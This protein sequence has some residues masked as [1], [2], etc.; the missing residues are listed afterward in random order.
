MLPAT[1]LYL[2]GA[3]PGHAGCAGLTA[4]RALIDAGVTVAA[5]AD[6]V[7]DP[8]NPTGR[9]DPLE[10]ASL[11]I[12]AGHLDPEEA[13]NAVSGAARSLD[14]S[15]RRPARE[16]ERRASHQGLVGE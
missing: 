6:N 10:T 1:N 11:L 16:D 3:G 5:G 7:R 9:L 13:L 2:Q 12:T 4:V 15:A 14:G 8:F